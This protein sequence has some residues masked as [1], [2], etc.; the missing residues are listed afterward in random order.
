MKLINLLV[1]C[2][3]FM[4]LTSCSSK[5]QP[6]EIAEKYL[7]AVD[8]FDYENAKQLV[9]PNAENLKSIDNIKNFGEKLTEPERE[10]YK[11]NKKVYNYVEKDITNNSAK[12][13]AT[14]NQGN[15]PVIIEFELVKKDDDWLIEK[16]KSN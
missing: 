14:S 8:N 7:T 11:S 16:F 10:K 6:K 5:R 2:L 3:T 12:V 15:Y 13:I 1:F 4:S 9:I